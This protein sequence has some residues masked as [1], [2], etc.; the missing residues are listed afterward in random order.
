MARQGLFTF[1]ESAAYRIERDWDCTGVEFVTVKT[2]PGRAPGTRVCV[3]PAVGAWADLNAMAWLKAI[4]GAWCYAV[5]VGLFGG[6]HLVADGQ[7]WR[8]R[9]GY[10]PLVSQ[11]GSNAAALHAVATGH[12]GAF[13]FTLPSPAKIPAGLVAPHSH[14]V[15]EACVSRT[16]ANAV[17]QLDVRLGSANT[18]ADQMATNFNMNATSGVTANVDTM[19]RVGASRTTFFS[20]NGVARNTTSGAGGAPDR[21]GNCNWDADMYLS[22]NIS[23]ANTN[24]A[25]SLLSYSLGLK[26]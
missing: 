8:P 18:T 2:G 26:V 25:F 17:A 19:A 10:I 15:Y 13:T 22:I 1:H 21:N 4:P 16:G 7:H 23:G 9:D 20:P 5:D 11:A 14:V 24:D 6:T 3:K 12:S